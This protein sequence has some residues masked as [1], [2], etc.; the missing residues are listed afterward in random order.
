MATRKRRAATGA[1]AIHYTEH[2]CVAHG[3]Y[4]S[5]NDRRADA[6]DQRRAAV[7]MLFGI[8]WL[9]DVHWICGAT[10]NR[11]IP[12]SPDLAAAFT[13]SQWSTNIAN[14]TCTR[15]LKNYERDRARDRQTRRD[16]AEICACAWLV[17][18]RD[19]GAPSPTTKARTAA[20]LEL[21]RQAKRKL[22]LIRFDLGDD[23]LDEVSA[24]RL[25]EKFEKRVAAL[26]EDLRVAL[27]PA[28]DE[29]TMAADLRR[30]IDRMI[31]R[32]GE[33]V[34]KVAASHGVLL[35]E[36]TSHGSN[37]F[38]RRLSNVLLGGR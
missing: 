9:S 26:D 37:R 11:R 10:V 16:R 13:A 8:E 31:E 1:R 32:A 36:A 22:S 17:C 25:V 29:Y 4:S 34:V 28:I 6:G 35:S 21:E 27:K 3:T 38:I 20:L 33:H 23:V 7:R 19:S 12:S 5:E 2:A 24:N 30:E 18:C 15:C 14:V